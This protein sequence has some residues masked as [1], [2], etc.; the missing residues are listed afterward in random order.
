MLASPNSTQST[1]WEG[2][3]A[4]GQFAFEG[5]YMSHAHGWATGPAPALSLY[6]LGLRPLHARTSVESKPYDFVFDPQPAEKVWFAEGSLDIYSYSATRSSST[7]AS[8]PAAAATAQ[9]GWSI[10]PSPDAQEDKDKVWADKLQPTRHLHRDFSNK[11]V[12]AYASLSVQ[13]SKG[14]DIPSA[15]GDAVIGAV[16]VLSQGCDLNALRVTASARLHT[17]TSSGHVELVL[18]DRFNIPLTALQASAHQ[19]L[20][21][22]PGSQSQVESIVQALGSL[23]LQ[24]N[25]VGTSTGRS[26]PALWSEVRW[27]VVEVDYV[28]ACLP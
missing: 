28:V 10:R 2:F 24:T 11:T 3:Q 7:R 27:P 6:M 15:R 16:R 18:W 12:F 9:A 21:Y 1:F 17:S 22:H 5:I 20:R 26:Q 25:L 19:Q 14:M 8:P 23:R 13:H 4:D